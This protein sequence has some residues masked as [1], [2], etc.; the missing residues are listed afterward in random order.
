MRRVRHPEGRK[1]DAQFSI[2]RSIGS[3]H[4]F[5]A[6]RT[7]LANKLFMRR[8]IEIALTC[9]LLVASAKAVRQL[10]I[11]EEP[12]L[13]QRV[14]GIVLDPSGAPIPDMVMTDRLRM[15]PSC[16]VPRKRMTK[17]ISASA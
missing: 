17:G 10:V 14:E 4:H 3:C 16:C 6:S 15:A 2:R 11:I 8:L 9:A 7:P 12:Q 13:A 1:A 5:V